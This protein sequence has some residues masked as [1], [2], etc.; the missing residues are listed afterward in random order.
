MKRTINETQ[1]IHAFNDMGR[2]DNFSYEGRR[3]LYEYL[4]E[5]E[6]RMGEEIGLDVIAMCCD[7]TEYKNFAEF[8]EDYGDE[9]EDLDDVKKVAIVIEIDDERFIIQNV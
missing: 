5:L 9:Y 2:G 8:K 6:E 4:T 7:F 1:F 3:A